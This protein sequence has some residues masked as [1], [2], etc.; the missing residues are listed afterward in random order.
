VFY[1]L[2]KSVML[3]TLHEW[4]KGEMEMFYGLDVALPL[5]LDELHVVDLRL[6]RQ[7][8]PPGAA[9]VVVAVDHVRR[10]VQRLAC[11]HL[12]G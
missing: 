1:G 12:I 11:R 7:H 3:S 10:N 5:H 2:K 6:V 9:Q 4:R 8:G